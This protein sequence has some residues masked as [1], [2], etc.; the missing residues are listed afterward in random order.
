MFSGRMR[1]DGGLERALE[2]VAVARATSEQGE[3][4]MLDRHV[5]SGTGLALLTM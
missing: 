4:G 2:L 1:A 3:D 5:T